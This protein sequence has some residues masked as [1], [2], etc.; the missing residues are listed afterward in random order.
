MPLRVGARQSKNLVSPDTPSHPDAGA[1]PTYPTGKQGPPHLT[2]AAQIEG[3]S[4]PTTPLPGLRPRPSFRYLT[5]PA[6]IL[7]PSEAKVKNLKSWGAGLLRDN[8]VNI[9]SVVKVLR[10]L[11]AFG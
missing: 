9:H 11:V 4:S 5:Y 8:H 1:V 10:I 3:Y 7:N 2:L 6:V